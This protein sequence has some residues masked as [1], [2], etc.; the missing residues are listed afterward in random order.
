[1]NVNVTKYVPQKCQKYHICLNASKLVFGLGSLLRTPLG[2]LKTLP[3]HPSRLRRPSA[4]PSSL[5]FGV[6][7]L[8]PL[9]VQTKFLA[10]SMNPSYRTC[11]RLLD[12]PLLYIEIHTNIKRSMTTSPRRNIFGFHSSNMSGEQVRDILIVVRAAL[13]SRHALS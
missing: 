9:Q 13:C 2:E 8:R 4:Y 10:T 3:R 1:V 5:D 6:S 7:I 11:A 12:T